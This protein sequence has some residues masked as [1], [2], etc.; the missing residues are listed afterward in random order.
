MIIIFY[1]VFYKLKYMP[2]QVNPNDT[3][4]WYLVKRWWVWLIF[5]PLV[6]PFKILAKIFQ[7]VVKYIN[8][9]FTYNVSYITTPKRKL[10]LKI[11]IFYIKQLRK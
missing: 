10:S 7:T 9:M 8:D 1:L 2:N 5:L 6:L 4:G 11:R 3:G